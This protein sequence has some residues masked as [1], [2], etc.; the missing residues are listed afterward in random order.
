MEA[1]KIGGMEI[2]ARVRHRWS[3]SD[4]GGRESWEL[5][6]E[7]SVGDAQ[8]L[9]VHD[10]PWGLVRRETEEDLSEFSVA[11]PIIDHRDGTVTAKM[12]KLTEREALE[13]ILG[14]TI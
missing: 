10:T 12:G 9:F 13:I 11:G 3:D 7:L 14:G 5:T 2:P 8:E 4:W 1:V 6:M